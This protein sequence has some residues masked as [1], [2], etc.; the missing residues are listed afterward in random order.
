V[1]ELI[2]VVLFGGHRLITPEPILLDTESKIGAIQTPLKAINCSASFNIDVSEHITTSTFPDFIREAELKFPQGC[3]N[4]TLTSK[5]G[6]IANFSKSSVMYGSPT[7]VYIKL[8]PSSAFDESIKYSSLNI[9]SCRKIN[10]AKITWYN[11]GKISCNA[12][13]PH[14]SSSLPNNQSRGTAQSCALGRPSAFGSGRPSRQTLGV[15][16]EE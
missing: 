10:A 5:D 3:L 11:Y 12:K 14:K 9:T 7:S 1:L 16:E 4:V 15:L 2:Q 8:K 6:K 13:R